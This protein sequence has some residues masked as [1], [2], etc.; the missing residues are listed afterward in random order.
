MSRPSDS[1]TGA[2]VRAG[3]ED[4][5]AEID[6]G[7]NMLSTGCDVDLSGFDLRVQSIC[8]AAQRLDGDAALAAAAGLS[9][10]VER[11][12]LLT[13]R[14]Q[15][16]QGSEPAATNGAESDKSARLRQATQAYRAPRFDRD[17]DRDDE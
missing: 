5:I 13:T 16:A 7:L 3:I 8:E 4:L 14:L 11:L 17:P 1:S 9:D 6:D 10:L 2:A 12:N 15:T